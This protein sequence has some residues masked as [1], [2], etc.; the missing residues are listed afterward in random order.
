M[1][2]NWVT[3]L[4]ESLFSNDQSGL[5]PGWLQAQNS[6]DWIFCRG[7]ITMVKGSSPNF[8]GHKRFWR[9]CYGPYLN[10]QDH[11]DNGSVTGIEKQRNWRSYIKNFI[12]QLINL[13]LNATWLLAWFLSGIQWIYILQS[14]SQ[15]SAHKHPQMSKKE[16]A[17]CTN[18]ETQSTKYNNFVY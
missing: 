10:I 14:M 11:C 15:K 16:E 8:I 9:V 13:L 4:T 1:L 2:S 18:P 12:F 17:K 3:C 6:L 7:N 5:S